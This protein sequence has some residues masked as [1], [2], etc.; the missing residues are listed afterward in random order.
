VGA[1]NLGAGLSSGM[2]V[3][4]SLSKTAVNAGA[5]AR[6]QLS[7]LVV[8]ALTVVTLLT[9]TGLF[10][11]LPLAT[12]AAVVIAAVIELVDVPSLAAL[13]RVYT[14]RLGRYY[15][16]TARPDF[17]A[18]VAA[19]LGV[20]VFGTLPGLF[21]GIAISLLLLIYRASRPHIAVLGKVPGT[22]GQYGDLE[23][24]PGNQQLAGIVILRVESGLFFANADAVRQS[25][26]AHAA[27]AG[28]RVV[29][30]DAETAPSIDVTAVH[31]LTELAGSLAREGVRLLV[32]R[33]IGQVRDVVGQVATD[34]TPEGVYPTV[35]AAVQAAQQ[36]P[37]PSSPD[38]PGGGR[39]AG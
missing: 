1:A 32:S 12:L 19:L 11:L 39:D 28:T 2:V 34:T 14:R 18:A 23:R 10:R 17:I 35:R 15:G 37:D 29:V 20:L 30:L 9:L 24:D 25:V 5:G 22:A 33:Q 4:G 13:Y 27:K 31:M 8:A 36:P 26:R 16:V 3:S 21:I 38:A 7:G 6:T